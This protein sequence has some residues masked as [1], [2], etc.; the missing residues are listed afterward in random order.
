M[1]DT[2]RSKLRRFLDRMMAAT[3]VLPAAGFGRSTGP[4]TDPIQRDDRV[5]ELPSVDE[6]HDQQHVDASSTAVGKRPRI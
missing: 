4:P 3:R 6:M 1:H 5:D 2:L